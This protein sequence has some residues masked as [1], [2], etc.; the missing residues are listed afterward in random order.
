MISKE[1]FTQHLENHLSGKIQLLQ[2]ELD[3]LRADIASDSK[4]TAGDKHETSRAMAQL[5]MEKLG[6]QLSDYQQQ[7]QWIKQ[8]QRQ[9][10]HP[11]TITVGSLIQ[12]SNGWYFLGPGIGRINYLEHFVFCISAHSPIGQ[13]LLHKKIGQEIILPNLHLKIVS[14]T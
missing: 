1:A 13:Q 10:S 14:I 6:G 4:S 11:E 8:L 3:Q 7:L 12:L 9:N 5:E 2:H